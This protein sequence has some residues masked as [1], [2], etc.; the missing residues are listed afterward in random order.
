M[1]TYPSYRVINN[2]EEAAIYE[3][4]HQ[5]CVVCVK[6]CMDEHISL[7]KWL[8]VLAKDYYKHKLCFTEF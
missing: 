5:F 6:V 4:W 7:K 8:S 1:N 2:I 3:R